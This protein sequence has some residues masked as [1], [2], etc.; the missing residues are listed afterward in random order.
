MNKNIK[1]FCG[2]S[3]VLICVCL[4]F[5]IMTVSLFVFCLINGFSEKN[6]FGI[7]LG[8]ALSFF[9]AKPL[10]LTLISSQITLKE[11]SF[12]IRYFENLKTF[13][14]NN[15]F[16]L[17]KYKTVEFMYSDI[18]KY[19]IFK[20]GELR[21]GGQDDQH[22]T[23]FIFN[24]SKTGTQIVM[25]RLIDDLQE[26]MVFND[27]MGTSVVLDTK[28]FSKKQVLEI[29]DVIHKKS[30]KAPLQRVIKQNL[31]P[32]FFGGFTICLVGLGVFIGYKLV[33][34]DELI[35]PMHDK[36]Y[37]SLL[38]VLYMFGPAFSALG[39]GGLLAC[40]FNSSEST[41]L[42][43]SVDEAKKLFIAVIL[44]GIIATMVGFSLSVLMA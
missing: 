22:R 9:I 26:F 32:M 17:P 18:A 35:V 27:T 30:G 12:Q 39:I 36:D 14:K 20:F 10:M 16:K 44:G 24:N 5:P 41:Q 4:L 7:G 37:N 33:E 15:W 19:G 23:I 43:S 28:I 3:I 29:F 40:K 6:L 25:P 31:P 2:T 21:K 34:L 1:P 8:I 42:V 13:N 38:R 11:N